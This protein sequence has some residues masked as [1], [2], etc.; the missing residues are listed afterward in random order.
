MPKFTTIVADGETVTGIEVDREIR[1]SIDLVSVIVSNGLARYEG[2]VPDLVTVKTA[3]GR[4]YKGLEKRG[5]RPARSRKTNT[6]RGFASDRRD[7]FVLA[8]RIFQDDPRRSWNKNVRRLAIQP[9][10]LCI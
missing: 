3:D 1:R 9:Q 2:R 8:L 7:D 4:Y 10:L 5:L 6:Q